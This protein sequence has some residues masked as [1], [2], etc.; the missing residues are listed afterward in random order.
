MNGAF[1]VKGRWASASVAIAVGVLVVFVAGSAHAQNYKADPWVFVGTVENC[2]VAGSPIVTA[3]WLKGLGLADTH[4]NKDGRTGL[5]LNKN[6]A[7]ADCSASGA[8][9]KGLKKGTVLSELGFDIRI[10]T[11][12]GAGAPR[13]N[14]VASD[15]SFYFAGGCANGDRS[16]APDDPAQW[17]RIRLTDADFFPATVGAPPFMLGVTQV[18][19]ID[20]VFDEGTDVPTAEAPSGV[21]LA[22]IDNIAVNGVLIDAGNGTAEP[23]HVKPPT[24]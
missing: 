13:F 16:P 14:V 5:L 4:P 19:S 6:G 3:A 18:D 23:K 24:P 10:G 2:G 15:G 9:I 11:H 12:C 22:T 1:V 7:T 17:E 8:T 21:G 20:I